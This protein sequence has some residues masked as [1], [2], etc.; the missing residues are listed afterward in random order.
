MESKKIK[1][2]LKQFEE[3]DTYKKIFINGPWGIGK[4]Y[5]TEEYIKEHPK[6]IVYISLFGKNSYESIE[7]AIAMELMKKL[8]KMKKATKKLKEFANK[9]KGPI[10]YN[11]ISLS[12]PDIEKKSLFQNYSK[13]LEN[14]KLII[15]IDDLERKSGNVQIEDIMG[16]IEQFSLYENIKVLIIGAEDK[17][18]DEDK[19]KWND[20]KEKIIEKEYK[21]T[22]FS[23]DAIES[24]VVGQLKEYISSKELKK[25]IGEFLE[26]HNTNNL[27][28][29]EKGVKLFLEVVEN[30]LKKKQNSE[31]YTPIL[32]NCMAV[33]IEFNE[34]LYKPKELNQEEKENLEKS[35]SYS[36]DKD[37]YSRIIK[38]YFHSIFIVKK[39][40]SI[41]E[42]IISFY[43]GE[44]TESVIDK[45]NDIIENYMN[46]KEE[47]NIYYLSEE[48]I[49]DRIKQKYELI[50]NDKYEFSTMEE[51]I[52]DFNEII[53]WNDNLEIGLDTT[54]IS[55]K[56]NDVMFTNYYSIEKE[57]QDNKIDTFGL[58]RYNSKKLDELIN[59]YNNECSKK[60]SEEKMKNIIDEYNKKT[61]NRDKLQWLDWI[62]IQD[63]KDEIKKYVIKEFKK[64]KYLIPDLSV[65]ISEDEWKWT[66]NIWKIYYERF[67]SEEKE[68]INKEIEKMKRNKL[69]I[70]RINSLQDYRPLVKKD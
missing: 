46:K 50:E 32:K 70:S 55:I 33:S 30:Y 41:L 9:F 63:N 56:F 26:K 10:S 49:I 62:L 51:T 13:L 11:G 39:E 12:S 42:Y 64:Y 34:E 53:V 29:I 69:S 36:D 66:H 15:V 44:I 25:F 58:V 68:I 8:N 24:I 6:N 4:S 23:E 21:I 18:N 35:L 22:S 27:R 65:E 31:T 54:N 3:N 43:N 2:I 67:S 5:Y 45:F 17:I 7:D 48:K 1:D 14:E 38:H 19:I 40:S 59:N 57:I 47:K 60:Y 37:M 20:F 52:Q 61:Y 28:S 16:L